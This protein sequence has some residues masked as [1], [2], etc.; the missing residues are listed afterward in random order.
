MGE[1]EKKVKVFFGVVEKLGRFDTIFEGVREIQ[2]RPSGAS[3]TY[4]SSL[5]SRP[6]VTSV[7]GKVVVFVDEVDGLFNRRR[8]TGGE[9]D[10][11]GATNMKVEFLQRWDGIS[12]ASSGINKMVVV[13]ASNR[14]FDIDAAFLRRMPRGYKVGRP[15]SKGRARLLKCILE[16]VP[17]Q[18]AFDY[19][20]IAGQTSGFNGSDLRELCECVANSVAPKV[21]G[22]GDFL[23][24]LKD[25]KPSCVGS[26]DYREEFRR[27]E[28]HSGAAQVGEFWNG[29]DMDAE[30]AEEEQDA[31]D[32]TVSEENYQEN[33]I[34]EELSEDFDEDD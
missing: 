20:A 7:G 13:G 25:F 18:E 16:G 28:G 11:S 34:L 2:S 22:L 4:P 6:D 33:D 15:N 31:F 17:I 29:K 10:G 24:A 21:M 32:E 5:G 27:E 30:M 3:S 26:Q 12:S 14:P 8:N 1:S 19:D 23:R 9:E